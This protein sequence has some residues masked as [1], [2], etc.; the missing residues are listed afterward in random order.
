MF[1]PSV[2]RRVRRLSLKAGLALVA[3]CL[4]VA[5]IAGCGSSGGG[6]SAN[7]A[8]K[9]T[10]IKLGFPLNDVQTLAVEVATKNGV[11]A[12]YGLNVTPTALGTASVVNA[13]LVSGS[14]DYAVTSA[15]Q[16]I[17]SISQG[18]GVIAISGYTVGTPSQVI[19]SNKLIAAHN[20]SASTP[21]TQ[22]VKA[23]VGSK[24]GVSSPVTE[25]QEA[26][27]LN[28]YEIK[29]TSVD[30]ITS[31][32]TSGLVALLK[33]GQIDAFI[34][35]PPVPQE[36]QAQ[37]AG[38]VM[39]TSK[40]A[41][42]WNAGNANLVL[43]AN[44]AYAAAHPALTKEVVAAVHAA[45]QYVLANNSKAAQLS[46]SLLQAPEPVLEQSIPLAGYSNCAK[47]SPDLW[48]R[49][50]QFS[51]AAGNLTYNASAPEGKVWTNAYA[52]AQSGC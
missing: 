21:I 3:G 34:S 45:V 12:K 13:A 52:P 15:S 8:P 39:I 1:M 18:A 31:N 49:T 28:S 38:Q 11:F 10:S 40:N 24:V 32:S 29:P 37:G 30:T 27:L 50:V 33:S 22:I 41:P 5:T 43:A 7:H 19:F 26:T 16:L 14:V 25:T 2:A 47:M 6:S 48:T 44:K 51:I 17:T 9:V 42:V 36:A 4:A 35:T 23:L 46:A 20:L